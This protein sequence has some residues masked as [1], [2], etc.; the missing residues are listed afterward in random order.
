[1]N[2]SPLRRP[3]PANGVPDERASK[4][5][6]R[7]DQVLTAAVECARTAGFHAA[8][9]AQIAKA[10]GLS[11]GQI[12]RYFENKEEIIAALV[13]REAA[14]TR[15]ALSRIDRSP[16]PLLDTITAHLPEEIDRCLEPGRTALRLEIL[17]EA[18]RNPAVAETVREADA[19]E[20]AL[21]AQLMA[22][23]R[24]PEWSDE[25]FQARLEMVGLMFDGLQTL[26]VRRPEVD[27]QA[28][29]GRLEAMI[30]LL[31]AQD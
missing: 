24:R 23:L 9:M 10:A 4:V 21:S 26:A 8:S 12:Y 13:A 11:V 2:A 18:A 15:E 5:Q 30:G 19:R 25:A 28:L 29:T 14:S 27:G 22:R 20:T 31:F 3:D 1:M 16:G 17:A 6:A 7:R